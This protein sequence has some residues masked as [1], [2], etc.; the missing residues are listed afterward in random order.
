MIRQTISYL[1]ALTSIYAVAQNSNTMEP[2]SLEELTGDY[3]IMNYKEY[4]GVKLLADMKNMR[5]TSERA[6]LTLSGFYMTGSEDFTAAYDP[7]DGTIS[8]EAGTQLL[9][10][11]SGFEQYIYL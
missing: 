4:E 11:E 3:V 5:M 6:T 8:I 1:L 2:P 9:G 10:G 7:T